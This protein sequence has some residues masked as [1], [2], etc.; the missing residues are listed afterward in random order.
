MLLK[1]IVDS[2]IN[3]I[4]P[5]HNNKQQSNHRVMRLMMDLDAWSLLLNNKSRARWSHIKTNN[6]NPSR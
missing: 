5:N 2:R 6:H 3:L 4:N 1:T